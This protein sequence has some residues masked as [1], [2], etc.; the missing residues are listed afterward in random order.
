V[1]P[2]DVEGMR[3]VLQDQKLGGFDMVNPL[4]QKQA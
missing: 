2:N 4:T 1:A 3:R